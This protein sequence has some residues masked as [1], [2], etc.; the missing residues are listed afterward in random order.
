MYANSQYGESNQ[1]LGI[2]LQET[3]DHIKLIII[4]VITTNALLNDTLF[5]MQNCIEKNEYRLADLIA[6]TIE[7]TDPQEM[8]LLFRFLSSEPKLQDTI[9][10][11]LLDLQRDALQQICAYH[12]HQPIDDFFQM[13]HLLRYFRIL[14]AIVQQ[15]KKK[16][17][18]ELTKNKNYQSLIEI[19]YRL[20][21]IIATNDIYANNSWKYQFT[22]TNTLYEL[23]DFILNTD[24]NS[25]YMY[26]MGLFLHLNVTLLPQED[27]LLILNYMESFES[28]KCITL[29]CQ[30]RQVME[31]ISTCKQYENFTISLQLDH[32]IKYC[33]VLNKLI[34]LQYESRKWID[35]RGC[36]KLKEAMYNI[37][38]IVTA[39][40]EYLLSGWR[41]L[42]IITDWLHALETI[43]MDNGGFK[44]TLDSFYIKAMQFF[45]NAYQAGA[46][47]NWMFEWITSTLRVD[48]LEYCFLIIDEEFED[49]T[50]GAKFG[51]ERFK[52][53]ALHNIF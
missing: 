52:T 39:N 23:N 18:N 48:T 44:F 50:R 35:V 8:H 22:L 29:L 49:S 26:G 5:H 25:Q 31:Q 11:I 10:P 19:F 33:K 30:A 41:H 9:D 3:M 27:L 45:L 15:N 38:H 7:V 20:Q 43:F 2:V 13:K 4:S 6:S 37:E 34:R 51:I 12:K 53:L 46:P 1:I 47:P 16:I 24:L 36:I 17:P 21:K 40:S 32:T 14:T 28:T 42:F